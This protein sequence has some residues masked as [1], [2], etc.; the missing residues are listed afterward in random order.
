MQADPFFRKWNCACA[1]TAITTITTIR[2]RSTA[3]ERR[4]RKERKE[5]KKR[6]KPDCALSFRVAL[7][8]TA[9]LLGAVFKAESSCDNVGRAA[10]FRA[11]SPEGGEVGERKRD[12]GKRNIK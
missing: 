9:H 2:R 4:E 3:Q 11:R 7:E 6:K 10:F 12:M 1:T 5:R 8:S